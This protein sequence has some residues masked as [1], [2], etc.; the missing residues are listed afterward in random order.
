MKELTVS[1]G[2]I[3]AVAFFVSASSW[4]RFPALLMVLSTFFGDYLR[5]S[6]VSLID[7]G[8]Y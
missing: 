4:Y 3:Y 5:Y 7:P 1:E 8:S 2:T 6:R